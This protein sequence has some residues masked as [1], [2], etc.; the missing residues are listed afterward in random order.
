MRAAVRDLYGGRDLG[1]FEGSFSAEA[2]GRSGLAALAWPGRAR[3][4]RVRHAPLGWAAGRCLQLRRPAACA[5]GFTHNRLGLVGLPDARAQVRLHDALALAI[6]PLEPAPS[7]RDWRPWHGQPVFERHEE[8][9]AWIPAP[10]QPRQQPGPA[11]A[12]AGA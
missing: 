4:E 2:S 12:A 1:V 10:L 6:T 5:R 9:E 3:A 11:A 7:H 8:D